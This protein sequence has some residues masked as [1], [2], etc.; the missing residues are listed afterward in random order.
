MSSTYI[1][2]EELA[3]RIH[4]DPLSAYFICHGQLFVGA[5]F[6]LQDSAEN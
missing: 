4:Y 1:T 2:T 3:S 6:F 5:G